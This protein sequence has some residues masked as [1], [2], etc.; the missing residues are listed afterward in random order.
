MKRLI[1]IIGFSWALFVLSNAELCRAD[2]V[3]LAL[4]GNNVTMS[5]GE[6]RIIAPNFDAIRDAEK[7]RNQNSSSLNN[8]SNRNS[9]SKGFPSAEISDS[10]MG[11]VDPVGGSARKASPSDSPSQHYLL[12]VLLIGVV[13]LVMIAA[14]AAQWWRRRSIRQN[15]LFPAVQED[16][17]H[18]AL[19]ASSPTPLIAKKQQ[20]ESPQEKKSKKSADR[21]A[22]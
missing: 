21:R 4:A 5:D 10:R 6:R 16:G 11:M 1:G 2:V 13:G 9:I 20:L 18:S 14:G 19:P 8:P 12:I 3:F 22:A 15:W 17:R 7:V